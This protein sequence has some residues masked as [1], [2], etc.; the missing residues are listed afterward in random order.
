MR[1]L[2]TTTVVLSGILAALV[3]A[4]AQE[5][6]ATELDRMSWDEP[7]AQ[8]REHLATALA[9]NPEIPAESRAAIEAKLAAAD[10]QAERAACLAPLKEAYDRLV[11]AYDRTPAS[12]NILGGATAAP[13]DPAK[14]DPETIEGPR[15]G[16]RIGGD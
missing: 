2:T 14:V 10:P 6:P 11:A 8:I 16:E 7:C 13:E 15:T 4:R 12:A 5:G 9:A 3:P 1:R